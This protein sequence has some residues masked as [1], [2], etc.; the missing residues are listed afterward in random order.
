MIIFWL[1][2]C[3]A[4]PGCDKIAHFKLA[5]IMSR[6]DVSNMSKRFQ[7]VSVLKLFKH[8]HKRETDVNPP[9]ANVD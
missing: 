2:L 5:L 8:F 3:K 4:I 6:Q 9:G 7:F 1:T